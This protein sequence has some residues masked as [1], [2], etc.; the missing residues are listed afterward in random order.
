MND[1]FERQKINIRVGK[2][3]NSPAIHRVSRLDLDHLPSQLD[4]LSFNQRFLEITP[5]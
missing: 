2:L 3:A 5:H 1:R 4:S